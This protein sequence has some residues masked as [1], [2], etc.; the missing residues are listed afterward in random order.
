MVSNCLRALLVLVLTAVLAPP[1]G[2]AV[3]VQADTAVARDC[4]ARLLEGAPGVEVTRA[5]APGSGALTVRTEGPS[6]SDWDLALFDAATGRRLGSSATFGSSEMATAYLPAAGTVLA[7]TCRRKGGAEAI[8]VSDDFYAIPLRP[9][10]ARREVAQLLTVSVDGKDDV[11]RLEALGLD[12]THASTEDTVDVATYTAEERADLRAA[13]FQYTV[14]VADMAAADRRA[15]AAESVSEQRALPSGRTTYRTSADY[16]KDLKALVEQF[17]GHVRPVTLPTKSLEGRPI[18][19]VEIAADVGQ[20]GEGRPIFLLA[21]L[22]HAREWPSGELA[23]EFAIDI[24]KTYAAGTDPRVTRMLQRSRVVV[25]PVLNPDGFRVS[26]D[27]GGTGQAGGDDRPSFGS[28]V[29]AV[30]DTAAYKRKNCRAPVPAEQG[31]PCESRL[32][33][34]VDLNR[35]YSAFW[36]GAGSSSNPTSQAFRGP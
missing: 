1:A 19:G 11:A 30:T 7:Q 2:A 23:I 24:A 10:G 31:T 26:R 32:T 22:T 5:S 16:S 14:R 20:A 34:G 18:E 27:I 9:A 28:I 29:E 25:L 6:S 35:A 13:G 21:G 4:D 8:T 36:G 33:S 3:R 17:P 15:R 12:V